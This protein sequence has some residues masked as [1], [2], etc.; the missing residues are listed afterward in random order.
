MTWD[1][2]PRFDEE[3]VARSAARLQGFAT[4]LPPEE[5]AALRLILARAGAARPATGMASTKPALIPSEAA[6]YQRLSA[7]PDPPPGGRPVLTVVMKATR[8]CNLRCVYCH[9]WREGPNQTMPFSVLARTTR[10]AL[11]DPGVRY[12]DFVWHGGEATLLPLSFYRNALWLQARFRRPG[13]VVLNTVQTNG[14][15]LSDPWL[16]FLRQ[17]DIG[18]GVSLD[19]PPEVHDARRVDT[20]GR[21]T[22]ARVRE[23]LARLEAAGIERW[24]ALMVVD[25]AV[26]AAGPRRILE[27]LTEAGVRRVALLNVLPENTPPG[28]P[29]AGEYLPF[30][31]FVEFLRELFAVWWPEYRERIAIRELGDLVGQLGGAPPSICVFAGDCFGTYLTVEPTGEVS[32]CD[33]Y[34]GDQDYRFS[35][36]AT[37]GLIDAH[38][39]E[40]LAQ[41]REENRRAVERM[42]ACAWFGVCHGGCPHDR[43]T[44]ER[45]L[46]GFDARCCGLAPLLEDMHATLEHEEVAAR[47]PRG[48]GGQRESGRQ[49]DRSTVGESDG[50]DA[51]AQVIELREGGKVHAG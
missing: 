32:A 11:R 15:R 50:D 23:G 47:P 1:A 39:S 41:A 9:S 34:V 28:E 18:V 26:I 4:A 48:K 35:D 10:D 27:Y 7:E 6:L 45:R 40:R 42:R 20:A 19:G 25:E 30:P 8:L 16:T 38:L 3:V 24:G 17:H 43:Y 13:Q 51:Q 22:S 33:K 49:P 2:P 37:A 44:G 36:G 21:P 14:T 12:V 46:P 31:R 5:Q 29:P